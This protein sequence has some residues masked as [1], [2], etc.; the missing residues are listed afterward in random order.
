MSLQELIDAKKEMEEARSFLTSN[1][2]EA[3][4]TECMRLFNTHLG[5]TDIQ[6]AQ[7]ASEYNDEGMYPGV[8]GPVANQAELDAEDYFPPWLDDYSDRNFKA[9]VYDQSLSELSRI[10]SA[11]GDEV[12]SEVFGDSARI[13]VTRDEDKGVKFTVEY[14]GY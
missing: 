2:K 3:I 4:K 7:K 9:S 5:L 11:A 14:V 10:L 12:L 13:I 6:F 8:Y 1:V